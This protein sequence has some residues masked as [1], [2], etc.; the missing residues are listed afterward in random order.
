MKGYRKLFAF[1]VGVGTFITISLLKTVQNYESLG[2]GI[3]FLVLVFTVPNMA[4]YVK[5][6]FNK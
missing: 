5:D 1:C 6:W 4:E 2:L 3:G